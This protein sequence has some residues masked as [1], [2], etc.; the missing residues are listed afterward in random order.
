MVRNC[1]HYKV[2]N[3]RSNDHNSHN[4]NGHKP[5]R[6]QTRVV[7]DRN[8]HR[9]KWPQTATATDLNGHRP[10]RPQT[11]WIKC[12]SKDFIIT[13][14][15]RIVQ[16]TKINIKMTK[17]ISVSFIFFKVLHN[18]L[19]NSCPFCLW[20]IRLVAILVCRHLGSWSFPF[21]AISGCSHFG[22]WLFWLWPFW[23]VA[24]MTRNQWVSMHLK[25]WLRNTWHLQM[26]EYFHLTHLACHFWFM[27]GLKLSHVSKSGPGCY[28]FN[29]LLF[30]FYW[31]FPD[32]MCLNYLIQRCIVLLNIFKNFR[33]LS[34][35]W[36][37]DADGSSL[38]FKM[39]ML[40]IFLHVLKTVEIFHESFSRPGWRKTLVIQIIQDFKFYLEMWSDDA[41]YHVLNSCLTYWWLE[42]WVW[43]ENFSF[44]Y[45]FMGIFR[46][47][48]N[49]C[50]HR[51]IT[52]TY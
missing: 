4:R 38:L 18:I 47:S 23:F 26:S 15:V 7:S 11:C 36:S 52:G 28:W 51:N 49:N 30:I 42:I 21:V 22:L 14:I 29:M 37:V 31:Y 24:T 25:L 27:E 17:D 8:G 20:L 34:Q 35:I 40:D 16:L 10:K 1:C 19:D 13:N 50:P 33:H 3:E 32:M 46:S 39:A 12:F 2:W 44:Q 5:E 41:P 48:F 45:F 9:P 6:P 43:Y